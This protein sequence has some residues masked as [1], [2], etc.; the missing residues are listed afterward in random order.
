VDVNAVT[1][2]ATGVGERGTEDGERPVRTLGIQV[3]LHNGVVWRMGQDEG[4]A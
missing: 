2:Q 3:V 1:M 4:W